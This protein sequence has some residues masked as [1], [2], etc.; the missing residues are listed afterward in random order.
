MAITV[1]TVEQ[2]QNFFDTNTVTRPDL[3]R[4]E[5]ETSMRVPPEIWNNK[6]KRGL[7]SLTIGDPAVVRNVETKKVDG[8]IV[9]ENVPIVVPEQ[10]MVAREI[11]V[12]DSSSFIPEIDP[13]YV[14]HGNAAIL[15]KLIKSKH[16][17]TLYLTGDSGT[18]KNVMIEQ[19]CAMNKQ[20]V[21]RVQ[22]TRD[23]KE[24][25][26]IGS[27][28]LI[29]GNIVYEDGPVIWAAMNGALLIL[30]ELDAGDP[31]E[32][33]CLQRVMEG[34]EFFVKSL[35]RM[36]K[37]KEGFAIISTSNTKGQGSDSGRW[38][39]TGVLNSAFLDRFD[40]C[41][42]QPYPN[43]KIEIKILENKY[44][45]YAGEDNVDT[46]FIEKV[47]DWVQII[48]RTYDNGGIDDIVSTRRA[49]GII[50]ARALW[51]DADKA[52]DFGISRFNDTTRDAFKI[53]WTK[54]QAGE[55]T[56]PEA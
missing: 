27:K 34:G 31:N 42:E 22:I 43:R 51:F 39:G 56:N 10:K 41:F 33:L 54:L 37:P 8:N 26:I 3:A 50:K 48:R 32:I 29:D 24:A 12:F 14:P 49:I 13:T 21:V 45:K 19:A 44:K 25:D 18:G 20:P 1:A 30:D 36:V 47:V 52:I 53:L 23:T 55:L 4:F 6:L 7:Y 35:N 11:N 17:F 16:F 2:V 38:I 15:D 40:M 46:N 5:R 9:Q 28:T